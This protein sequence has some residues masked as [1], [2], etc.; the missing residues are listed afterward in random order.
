MLNALNSML[1]RKTPQRSTPTFA[2]P[3]TTPSAFGRSSGG[4]GGQTYSKVFRWRLPEGQTAEPRSV[5][6][7][8]S[9]THWQRV[10]LHR[11]GKLD[12]WHATVHHIPGNK[13][14]HYML[15]IDGK[16]SPDKNCDGFAVPHG[17]QEEQYAIQTA[18]GPRV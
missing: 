8:G 6:I 15:L 10:P 16:P 4:G 5:E 12:S 3:T 7:V 13:T 9:C 11:D 1:G 14:H 2:E 18:R 17:P